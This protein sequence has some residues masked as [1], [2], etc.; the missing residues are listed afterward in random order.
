M[1]Y[2]ISNSQHEI[3]DSISRMYLDN[4]RVHLDLCYNVGGFYSPAGA[5]I[6]EPELKNDLHL[7]T[8]RKSLAG[9]RITN[10][11]CRETNLGTEKIRSIV[12]DPPFLV[13]SDNLMTDR[14]GGFSSIEEM[15][16]FQDASLQEISRILIKGG[17]LITKIQDFC[18]GRQKYFPSIY[19]V[20]KAREL[21]LHLVDSF[22]LI[23]KNRFRAKTAGRLTAVSAHCFFHV[24]RK[25]TRRKRIRR[26]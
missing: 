25:G 26:Y 10:F 12:F 18:H 8:S 6:E 11:D 3:L 14:Y 15:F 9:S 22:I 4:K 17:I 13:G 16:S 5:R 24:F 21:N 1:H 23:N 20:I 19:Q 2:T 7:G